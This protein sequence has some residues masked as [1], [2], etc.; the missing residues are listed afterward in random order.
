ME[1][2]VVSKTYG[3]W[4]LWAIAAAAL[5][6]PSFMGRANEE[7]SSPPLATAEIRIL[8]PDEGASFSA[9]GRVV[10][11]AEAVDPAGD[12]RHL[13]FF[14]NGQPIGASDYLPKIATIPGRPIPHRLEWND[15]AP[16]HY[17][18]VARG[19][20]T[21][22]ASVE[23]NAVEIDV[24]PPGPGASVLI[25]AGSDW[26]YLNDGT[27]PG[28]AWRTP[29]FDDASWP[30][31]PA[32]LG[33]GDG[34]E[35]TVTRDAAAETVHPITAYF[36]HAFEIPADEVFQAFRIRLLRDDGA[37]V[38]L[39]GKEVLRDNMPDGD[40]TPDTTASGST[41]RENAFR[42]F[43]LSAEDLRA[44]SNLLAVEVHQHAANSSDL[45]F[46]LEGLGLPEF[47]ATEPAVVSIEATR[48]TTTEP[49]PTIRVAPGEFTL[50]RQG[51]TSGALA[52]YLAYSG[53]ATA[54]TDYEA[55]PAV[56]EIPAGA[57]ETILRVVP[58][59][60]REPEGDET[61]VARIRP[62]LSL[63]VLLPSYD[64]DPEHASAEVAIHDSGEGAGAMLTLDTPLPGARFPLGDVVP[65]EATAVDPK[66]A[67][68]RVE[69]FDGR[70]SIGV[71]EIAFIQ[72]PE[73]GT[74]IHHTFEWK[75][76]T[77]GEHHLSAR[78]VDTAGNPVESMTVAV[79]VGPSSDTT[80]VGVEATQPVTSEPLPNALILP[81][82]FTV[83]RRGSTESAL[84]VRL[85]YSGTATAGVDYDELPAT[86]EI[87]AGTN[88]VSLRVLA[89]SDELAEG[90]ER[91]VATVLP[92]EMTDA[93]DPAAKPAYV[94][95]PEHARA[96]VEI[97]DEDRPSVATLDITAPK[98]DSRFPADGSIEIEAVAID[99][100][101]YI[102][103]VVFYDGTEE[104]GVS[105]IAFI[106]APDPGTPVHHH[107]AWEHPSQGE[108]KLV[109][110]ATDTAGEEVES[111]PVPIVVGF[112]S[113][114]VVLGLEAAD[115]DAIE[116]MGDGKADDGVIVVR[117]VAGPKEPAVAFA[118]AIEG[119]AGNGVDYEK[120]S[121]EGVLPANADSV[122]IRIHPLADDLEE[123]VERVV[124]TLRPLPCIAI[125]PPPPDC[126]LIGKA[127]SATVMIRDGPADGDHPPKVAMDSPENGAVFDLGESIPLKASAE[128]TDG[129]LARLEVIEGDTVLGSSDSSPLAFEWT[130]AVK[131]LHKLVAR[132]VDDGG[133]SGRSQTVRIY[134]RDP[135]ERAFV[136]RVLPPAY[137]PER[138]IEVRLIVDPPHGAGAWAIEEMPPEGWQV[139]EISDDGALDSATGKVKFGPFLDGKDQEL[140]YRS[141]PPADATGEQK[142][143]GTS[144]LDGQ[145]YPVVGD[146]V[147]K[148]AGE[149]HPADID[150][151]DNSM[152][153]DE[154]TAYA[155]AWKQ[156]LGW[157]ESSSIPMSYVSRAG[158]LWKKGETYAFDP[159]AGAPPECWVPA[160]SKSAALASVLL[161][162]SGSADR[163]IPI[164]WKPGLAS[165]VDIDVNPPAGT[166]AITVE[167]ILPDGWGVVSVSDDG[168]F[169]AGT[170][171]IRWGLLFGDDARHL[172]FRAAPPSGA[173]STGAFVG[174][175][176]FDGSD[177]PIAGD[178]RTGAADDDTT[179][180]IVGSRREM[181][182]KIHLKIDAAVDQVFVVEASSDLRSWVELDMHV[183]TG[184]EIDV[185]DP[186]SDSGM[187]HRY[188]R[189]RPI[190]R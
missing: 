126:Y 186:A 86:L 165:E 8:H 83:F 146:E 121:G 33:Y 131:G 3:S 130:D 183:F 55:L 75:D 61:V 179:L 29:E 173:A 47:H 100:G 84:S 25:A 6:H 54:G 136:R 132:A 93:T 10:V 50:R 184:D 95:D 74:P 81:G 4:G 46:D 43:T 88:K 177:V 164:V 115:S 68:T 60:D 129:R 5:F 62:I 170:G 7:G 142:F 172:T 135:A 156:G 137:L 35:K 148:P 99:P 89:R 138:A 96:A 51:E 168:Q 30:A 24:Q 45:S 66:G 37:V 151:Q 158:F 153:A 181:G 134:V 128:D 72:A 26:R 120:L 13:D 73:P 123:D 78:A 71:S 80:V 162:G 32:Q 22:G 188:Y 118:Y 31:G 124:L 36:R 167:E 92:P 53:T 178:S 69:F 117:R 91:V 34:D 12:I 105:E 159:T 1:A 21:L 79:V 59:Q 17:R 182:G 42:V 176:S 127:H 19:I 15:V 18:L 155:S 58:R 160:A 119:S 187:P 163:E 122:E 40:V 189:L 125:Y 16:G 52:V 63:G 166:T 144:S 180:R 57:S 104:I 27:D 161:P 94:V 82:E 106:V 113:I 149:F 111:A 107:L 109:A 87:P 169:D 90:V 175:A 174:R 185:N 171:R 44:G 145:Q 147:L 114:Q 64:I 133:K 11:E 49:G 56:V 48:P 70:N 108:H 139:S 141:T 23:S 97:R 20:D 14:A 67:I 190:G 28:E 76:A 101:G 150:P 77:A 9:P 110:R 98:A 116:P 112:S 39:N 85:E 41:D 103:R 65:I 154:V 140:S 38:Y 2:K 157:K 143:S 152:A 102:D